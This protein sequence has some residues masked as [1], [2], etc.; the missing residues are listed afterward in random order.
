MTGDGTSKPLKILLVTQW[1]DPEPTFKGLTFAKA[2]QARGHFVKVLTGF[3]NYPGGKLYP[4]YRLSAFQHESLDGID[5]TR[6]YLHP[7]HDKSKFGRVFNYLSFFVSSLIYLLF[8]APRFD[9]IYAYHPPATTGLSVAVARIFRRT[10]T[11][12]DIQDMWPDTLSS[13]GVIRNPRVLRLIGAVCRFIYNHVDRIIVLSPG[14]QKLLVQ[15]G[16]ETHHISIIRN[17]ADESLGRQDELPST[18]TDPA[19]F[20]IMFSGNMGK[21]QGLGTIL[22][23]AELLL[24]SHPQIRIF[25][26]GSGTE[27]ESL[28]LEKQ[29]RNLGNVIFLPRVP[30]QKVGAYLAAADCLLVHLKSDPLFEITIPSKTQA[31]LV[32]GKPIIMAVAGDA[33]DMLKAAGAGV[34]AKSGDA[35]DIA[36]AIGKMALESKVILAEMGKAGREYYQRELCI[37]TGV[38]KFEDVFLELSEK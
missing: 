17:W 1:F 13:T 28:K 27:T 6:V 32:A 2:L 8:F 10:P 22:D 12:L 14:F 4:G 16:V 31:Y 30:M 15:R 11:A 29:S 35:S 3:P 33:A 37:A 26:L 23:A 18:L 20:K 9:V 24:H 38:K 34:T 25:L 5:V 7:S 19:S 21:A 36:V